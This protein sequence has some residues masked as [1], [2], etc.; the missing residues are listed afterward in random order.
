MFPRP[1]RRRALLLGAASV[2]VPGCAVSPPPAPP[3]LTIA[4]GPPGAVF[5]EIGAALAG[6]LAVNLPRTRVMTRPSAA[7]VEN[8]RLL[9][10]GSV[11]LGLASLDAAL[12]PAAPSRGLSAVGRLYDSFLHLVV[13]ADSPVRSLADLAGRTVSLGAVGSGTEFTAPRMLRLRGVPV[14]DVRMTQADGAD[15]L[16]ARRI[17]ALFSLTGIPTPAIT[18]LA[19]RMPIRLVPLGAEAGALAE[20]YPGPY[21]P[22]TVPATTYPGVPPSETVAVPNLLLARDDLP[23]DVVEVV[24]RTVFTEAGRIAAGHPEAQRINVRTGI[25]TGPVP[26][27][28]GAARWFRTNKR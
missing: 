14:R 23:A 9:A 28:P 18:G 10:A 20:T 12:D 16:A 8:L 13:L 2:A 19:A 15:A 4:T 11:Q 6:A 22:A 27:H 17:D 1:L 5:R 21:A 26:L 7:T 25:A 3:E 24:T